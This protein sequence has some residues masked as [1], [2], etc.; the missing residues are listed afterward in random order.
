MTHLISRKAGKK[1]GK[2]LTFFACLASKNL[3]SICAFCLSL[4][5]QF[6]FFEPMLS[7]WSDHGL[8]R[9]IQKQTRIEL[10]FNATHRITI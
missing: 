6:I 7:D 9:E 1:P 4:K 10:I 8:C 2:E 3:V 5:Y